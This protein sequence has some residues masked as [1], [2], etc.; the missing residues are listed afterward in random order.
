[1]SYTGKIKL[2]M[3]EELDWNMMWGRKMQNS[4]M[5][6]RRK[7]IVAFWDKRA[8]RFEELVKRN[9]RAERYMDRMDVRPEYTVLDIGAGPGTLAIPLAKQSQT[10]TVVEPSGVMLEYLQQEAKKEKLKKYNL[11]K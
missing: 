6:V 8:A 3:M 10:V 1:M 11:Y 2:T 5:R 4:S 7:D 9:R